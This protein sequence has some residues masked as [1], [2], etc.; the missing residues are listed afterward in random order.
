MVSTEVSGFGSYGTIPV[1]AGVARTTLYRW[2]RSAEFK[3]RRIC[4]P[5]R[6]A[7]LAEE[8]ERLA[9]RLS[10]VGQAKS[11]PLVREIGFPVSDSTWGGSGA[12]TSSPGKQ[13]P[14]Q[15]NSVAVQQKSSHRFTSQNN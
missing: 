2:L 12:A 7:G 10:D 13:T 4:G 15:S 14:L 8:V 1:R 6:P 9:P 3:S 11:G 5:R